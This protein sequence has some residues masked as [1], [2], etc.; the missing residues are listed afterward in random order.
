MLFAIKLF[1]KEDDGGIRDANRERHLDYLSSFEDRTWFAGPILTE[2]GTK[3]LGSHRLLDLTDMAEALA[4]VAAEPYVEAGLQY[5][6]EIHRWSAS[7]PYT[8]RDCP[9]TEGNVQFLIHAVERPD[10]GA[11]REKLWAERKA[12]D[13]INDHLFITRGPLLDADNGEMIGSLMILDVPDLNAAKVFWA[14][15]PFNNGGLFERVEFYGWRFGRVF[16]RFNP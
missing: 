8:W 5:G 14:T 3:E 11:L 12:Y 9:R 7:V 13:A 10:G 6:A 4:H 1:D 2:D 15:E 16:D